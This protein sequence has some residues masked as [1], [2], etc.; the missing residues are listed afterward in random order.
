MKKTLARVCGPGAREGSLQ[1]K[2]HT[3]LHPS[4]SLQMELDQAQEARRRQEQQIASA[5]E[6]LKFVVGAMN[7]YLLPG[8]ASGKRGRR[9]QGGG[10][11]PLYH[12]SITRSELSCGWAT[13]EDPASCTSV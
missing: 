8:R 3:K 1:E 12:T 4:Q 11:P 2:V 5:E 9:V 10:G 6:Q 7:R 13:A